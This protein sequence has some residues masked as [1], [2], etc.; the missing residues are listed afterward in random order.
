MYYSYHYKNNRGYFHKIDLVTIHSSLL[1]SVYEEK[2]N[3][4]SWVRFLLGR[5]SPDTNAL[6]LTFLKS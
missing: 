2:T 4:K 6:H 5:F 1:N 3:P